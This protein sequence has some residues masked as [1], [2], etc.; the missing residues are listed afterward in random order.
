MENLN[1]LNP[2]QETNYMLMF[3]A[4]QAYD[5]PLSTVRNWIQQGKIPAIK[6]KGRVMVS[7]EELLTNL[8]FYVKKIKKRKPAA[9]LAS[10]AALS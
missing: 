6:V 1:N 10:Y 5:V 9:Y 8:R 4:C 2:T 7:K 3:D